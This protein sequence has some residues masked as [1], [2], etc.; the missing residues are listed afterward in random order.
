MST[1]FTPYSL[2]GATFRNR[3]AVSPMCQ[4]SSVDG[5]ANDWHT[6]HYTSFARGGAG[7][8]VIEA[9]AVSPEGRITPACMGLWNVQGSVLGI[10]YFI[11]ALS[12]RRRRWSRAST[13]LIRNLRMSPARISRGPLPE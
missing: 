9:T 6:T 3:I 8:V 10:W 4:Y 11:D 7:L 2:K 13:G 5:V 1:L 12:L